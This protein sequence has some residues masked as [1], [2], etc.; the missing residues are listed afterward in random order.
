MVPRC[1]TIPWIAFVAFGSAINLLAQEPH[2][3]TIPKVEQ[4][5]KIDGKLDDDCW[6]KAAVAK[7]KQAY[8]LIAAVEGEYG[9]YLD[10]LEA[11]ARGWK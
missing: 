2:L 6:P 3:L 7:A 11:K 10:S 4:A 1:I 5:P 8:D 9:D